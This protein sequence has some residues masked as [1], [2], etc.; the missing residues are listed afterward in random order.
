[1]DETDGWGGEDDAL[2]TGIVE[3]ILRYYEVQGDWQMLATIT[4][5]L[6]FGRDRRH[7]S[8]GRGGKYQLL[9]RFDERR[10]VRGAKIVVWQGFYLPLW[11]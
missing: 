7:L 3:N 2:T 1:M 5:V 9:P 10:Y 4:C 8:R 6:T 11:P